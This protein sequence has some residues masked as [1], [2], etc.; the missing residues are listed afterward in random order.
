MDNVTPSEWVA[1]AFYDH[2]ELT[3]ENSHT[4]RRKFLW[5]CSKEKSEEE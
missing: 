5:G 2:A 4:W 3:I 1:E